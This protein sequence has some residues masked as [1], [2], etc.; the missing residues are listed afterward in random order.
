VKNLISRNGYKGKEARSNRTTHN[1]DLE[2]KRPAQNMST[3]PENVARAARG[4][5]QDSFI[6]AGGCG[7]V[8]RVISP[9]FDVALLMR[10]RFAKRPRPKRWF[11]LGVGIDI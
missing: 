8:Y 11:L 6:A 5:V 1:T 4:E 7:A 9:L 2:R 10:R 3:A